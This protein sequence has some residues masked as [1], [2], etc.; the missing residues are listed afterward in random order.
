M[1]P[2]RP[3]SPM[4]TFASKKLSTGAKGE[5]DRCFR[6]TVTVTGIFA[7]SASA[8]HSFDPAL[9]GN[10]YSAIRGGK[11]GIRQSG[12]EGDR[13]SEYLVC[14]GRNAIFLLEGFVMAH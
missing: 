11:A 6:V 13:P 10:L 12:W 2:Q 7:V 4:L 8:Q 14:R 1:S 5:E 9:M 3:R